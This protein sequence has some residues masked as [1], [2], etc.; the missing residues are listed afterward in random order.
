MSKKYILRAVTLALV[1]SLLFTSCRTATDDGTLPEYGDG[2]SLTLSLGESIVYTAS[3]A[4]A[5][6][7]LSLPNGELK[8]A[9]EL[10]PAIADLADALGIAFSDS[11]SPDADIVVDTVENLNSRGSYGEL[12]NLYT[13]G[14]Y[15]GN[16]TSYLARNLDVRT[17][18]SYEGNRKYIYSAPIVYGECAIRDLIFID[19]NI[20]TRL[21]DGDGEYIGDTAIAYTPPTLSPTMPAS[22]VVT[23]TLSDSDGTPTEVTKNYSAAGNPLV[24]LRI[25]AELGERDLDS[26]VNAFRT[27]IDDAY[28]GLYSTARSDL[29]LGANAVYDTDELV[30]LLSLIN[31]TATEKREK[32][33]TGR[34]NSE[35]STIIFGDSSHTDRVAALSSAG[36]LDGILIADSDALVP[37]GLVPVLPPYSP[38]TVTPDTTESEEGGADDELAAPTPAVTYERS[39]ALKPAF[40]GYGIAISSSVASNG[41]KLRAALTFIDYIFSPTASNL[42]GYYPDGFFDSDNLSATVAHARSL[43]LNSVAYARRFVGSG[44]LT[45]DK[46][47]LRAFLS[48]AASAALDAIYLV[49]GQGNAS[50]IK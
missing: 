19:H 31:A 42:L 41:Q 3:D 14:D 49:V 9:G 1:I 28:G 26:A 8:R 12:I 25:L 35:I 29:F 24:T 22:G 13:Y 2:I 40:Y 36:L 11:D 32:T 10:K 5:N 6:G 30:A 17:A 23:L 46:R 39:V 48:D 15:T 45:V 37:D 27:Y 20:V 16:L 47:L 21:L 43:C 44:I 4:D 7:S 33:D 34:T 18:V 50:V 38:R